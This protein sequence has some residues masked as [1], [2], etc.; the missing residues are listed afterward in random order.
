M[1]LSILILAAA[2]AWGADPPNRS[3]EP[4][5]PTA[6]TKNVT[7]EE[8]ALLGRKEPAPSVL[9]PADREPVHTAYEALQAAQSR[10]VTAQAQILQGQLA[11]T[12]I[13]DLQ[14]QADAALKAYQSALDKPK[15]KCGEL[16]QDKDGVLQCAPKQTAEA[17]PPGK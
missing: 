5:C 8:A 17:K 16:T 4:N 11:Q 10:V 6:I 2:L 1:K 12:Q 3:C 7:A 9:T 15:A 13:A 14:K